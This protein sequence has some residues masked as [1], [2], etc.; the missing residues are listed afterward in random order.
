MNFTDSLSKLKHIIDDIQCAAHTA[1]SDVNQ[2][3]GNGLPYSYHLDSVAEYVR[4]YGHLVCNLHQDVLPLM[5]GAYFHDSIEDARLSYN[6]VTKKALEIGLSDVQAYMGAEIVYALTNE[7]GRTRE[8]RANQRYYEGIR[9]TPYAPFCKMC[10]RLANLNFSAQQIDKSNIHMLEIY[11]NELPH[12][13]TAIQ[14]E[15]GMDIRRLV[16]DIMIAEAYSLLEH[17]GCI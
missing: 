15:K 17:K 3:Y 2:F 8:E 12:F 14:P 7:K 16:P 5:F 1:H 9:L 10:D 6:D 11:R 4:R 13:I